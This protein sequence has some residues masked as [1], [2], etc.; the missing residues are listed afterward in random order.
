MARRSGDDETIDLAARLGLDRPRP[1]PAGG[2][3]SESAAQPEV[4]HGEPDDGGRRATETVHA[5]RHAQARHRRRRRARA[6]FWAV[7]LVVVVAALLVLLL[8]Q[9]SL[10][11]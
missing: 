10:L 11:G 9:A 6:V 8:R 5:L 3:P 7:V 4:D 2:T 1:A